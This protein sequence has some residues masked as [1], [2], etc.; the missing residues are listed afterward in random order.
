MHE[1][2]GGPV[3]QATIKIVA[4][5]EGVQQLQHQV[6]QLLEFSATAEGTKKNENEINVSTI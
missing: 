4:Y 1:P 3:T 5:R 2:A 6:P